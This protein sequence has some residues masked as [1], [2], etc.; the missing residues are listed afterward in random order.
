MAIYHF[1]GQ[2]IKRS[3]GKSATAAAAYRAGTEIADRTIGE[4]FDYSRKGGVHGASILAPSHAPAW[5]FDRSE[6]WNRVEESE[7]RVNSQLA[8]EFN[9][10]IPIE[11]N[12]HDR[13]ELVLEFVQEQFVEMGMVADVAFHD[14]DS[15]N[16]HCHVMLSTREV[17]PEGFTV[18]NRSWNSHALMDKWR[19][20]WANNAN[21]ALEKAGFDARIDHRSYEDQ[22]L[23]LIPTRHLGPAA[24]ALEA[25]GVKTAVGDINRSIT[26]TNTRY[27]NQ[28]VELEVQRLEL[29]A[30]IE[31]IRQEAISTP[32]TAPLPVTS[33]AIGQAAESLSIALVADR[34]S[35]K[36]STGMAMSFAEHFKSKLLLE[37][38]H[39]EFP[40]KL[41]KTL[42]W[43]DVE[44]R[45]LTMNSGSQIVDHGGKITLSKHE[46]DALAVT[47]E[48]IKAKGWDS[49]MV[50]G[51]DD[52]QVAT[53]LALHEEGIEVSLN[54]EL[55]KKRFNDELARLQ[56]PHDPE[57]E[58][59][60][61][62]SVLQPKPG[63]E[64]ETDALKDQVRSVMDQTPLASI[65][66]IEDD[67]V[68]LKKWVRARWNEV[69]GSGESEAL[70]DAFRTV[71]EECAFLAGYSV[72]S[73][74]AVGIDDELSKGMPGYRPQKQC[75]PVSL[76]SGRGLRKDWYKYPNPAP[77]E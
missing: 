63:S 37:N 18:K 35:I 44:S 60:E 17:G 58:S 25:R 2:I 16:P 42:K 22:G 15:P 31:R 3:E 30:E 19:E 11:L 70:A 32:D 53:A 41:L 12:D 47:V 39:A 54:S 24:A 1:S 68:R 43:V 29:A 71:A 34:E 72:Q 4:V 23:D 75:S 48:M 76:G 57:A 5:V 21:R 36:F 65:R 55:A 56:A 28:Q 40:P 33:G 6:L 49:V 20:A 26:A 13:I 10:G 77:P 62:V 45:S 67:P 9:I 64:P 51:E 74:Q 38:W 46:P 66:I 69:S 7:T 14:F 59:I 52:F 61:P 27:M 73:I 8:R 50:S